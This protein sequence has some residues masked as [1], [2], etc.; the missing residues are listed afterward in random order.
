MRDYGAGMKGHGK[1][2]KR[3]VGK[4]VMGK[5]R[6]VTRD[7]KETKGIGVDGE[8]GREGYGYGG[9]RI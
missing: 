9:R 8:G 3:V 5:G 4:R 7:R 1:R 2:K 6:R